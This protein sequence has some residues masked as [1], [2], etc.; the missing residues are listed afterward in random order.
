MTSQSRTSVDIVVLHGDRGHEIR[1]VLESVDR[2]FQ[3]ADDVLPA[4]D[5]ECLELARVELCQTPAVHLVALALDG[6][7]LVDLGLKSA[8]AVELLDHAH[9]GVAG[10]CQQPAQ[11]AG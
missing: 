5:G 2:L 9:V 4:Q 3:L 6:V 8:Q 10:P 11:L 1:D 7:D